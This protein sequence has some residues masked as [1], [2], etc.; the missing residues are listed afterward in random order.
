MPAGCDGVLGSK[1]KYS[2]CGVCK[3]DNAD[4]KRIR[5]KFNRVTHGYT[6]ILTLPAGAASIKIVQRSVGST[7]NNS[8][9]DN[10]YLALKNLEGGYILNGHY[11]LYTVKKDINV[12][13]EFV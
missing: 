10:I 8:T 1:A 3:G 12:N 5:G 6:D 9:L 13:G 7:K 2:K 11:K 4:C